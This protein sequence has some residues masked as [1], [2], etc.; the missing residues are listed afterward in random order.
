MTQLFRRGSTGST[1]EDE[2][3][4]LRRARETA[5]LELEAM[6]RELAERILAL[7]EREGE[8][9][10]ALAASGRGEVVGHAVAV[11][12]ANDVGH[13]S[14]AGDAERRLAELREAERLFLRTRAELSERSETIAARERLV[15]DRERRLEAVARRSDSSLAEPARTP[16]FEPPSQTSADV[17]GFGFAEGLETLRRRGTRR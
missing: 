6:K 5:A 3:E 9:N 14:T 17:P 13:E 12:P 10:A 11:P 16:R 2:R 8:L 7:R 4:L 15:A 1:L